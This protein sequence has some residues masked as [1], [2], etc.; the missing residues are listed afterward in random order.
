ME[1][2]NCDSPI[3]GIFVL[4][5]LS[6]LSAELLPLSRETFNAQRQAVVKCNF[7]MILS[8]PLL[9]LGRRLRLRPEML[10]KT[11]F[12]GAVLIW[13]RFPSCLC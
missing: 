3:F 7:W 12:S 1:E 2:E 8:A 6:S 5:R 10:E 13:R 11:E 9:K 4:K